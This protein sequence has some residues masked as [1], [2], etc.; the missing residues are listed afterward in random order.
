MRYSE[1]NW[2]C[3]FGTF[4][5]LMM[6]FGNCSATLDLS[7]LN[8][9]DFQFFRY[10]QKLPNGEL[11]Q[12]KPP[13][14]SFSSHIQRAK[15]VGAFVQRLLFGYTGHDGQTIPMVFSPTVDHLRERFER[16]YGYRGQ[17]LVEQLGNGQFRYSSGYTPCFSCR[18]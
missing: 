2:K 18:F 9:N 11:K 3:I 6:T 14:P 1:E 17:H 12:I 10:Q 7:N 8:L 5:I 13:P 15:A 4:F 16:R